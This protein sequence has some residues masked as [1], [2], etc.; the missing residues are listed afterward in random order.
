MI[1]SIIETIE[2]YSNDDSHIAV[3]YR[4]KSISYRD[5]L[6]RVAQLQNYILYD[7]CIFQI[8]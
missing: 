1:K 2:K 7:M 4:E 5:L 6:I 8:N 3:R